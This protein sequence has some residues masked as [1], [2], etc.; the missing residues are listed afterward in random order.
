MGQAAMKSL[1]SRILA[2]L[3][4]V[5]ILALALLWRQ[6]PALGAGGLLH[7]GRTLAGVPPPPNCK[8]TDFAGAGVTLKGWSCAATAPARATIVYLHGIA[9]NRRSATGVIQRFVPREFNVVAY[10]SRAHGESDGDACTYGL[11]EKQDLRLVID[12]L[13]TSPV[14]LIGTSLG[15]AVALQEAADDPRVRAVVAAE[16]FSDLRT[17]AIER[18]PVFFTKG[19]IERAFDAAQRESRLSVDEV[20]PKESARR[21]TA[22]VLVIHGADDVE[23]PPAHSERVYGALNGPKRLILVPGAG[24]N[25]S[26]RSDV[27]KQIEQWIDD[28]LPK[29]NSVG[30]VSDGRVRPAG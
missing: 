29:S 16:T 8:S 10:D 28:V 25:G 12:T 22:S 24:H 26:L 9:D 4:A 30:E 14:V 20:Q 19:T 18:A 2:A 21:I 7:P 11:F 23:T 15:A 13:G 5:L 3:G 17:V 27:W 6:L 1:T